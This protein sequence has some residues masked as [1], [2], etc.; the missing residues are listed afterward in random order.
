MRPYNGAVRIITTHLTADFDAFAAAVVARRL[1]PEHEVLFPGSLE[2]A[3]RRFLEESGFTFEELR[4]R[5]AR[6]AMVGHAVVVDTRNPSRLG[7]V[8]GLIEAANAPVTLIDHHP[9][10]EGGIESEEDLSRSA[11]ATSTII[12]SLLDER[13]IEPSPEEASLLLMGIH[14]DT[15]SLAYAETTPEDHRAAAWLLERGASLEWVRRW[16]A[17]GLEPSQLELLGRLAEATEERVVNGVRVAI[18]A[19][20]VDRYHEEAAYVVHRWVET[21]DHPV[22][23]ALIQNPPQTNV[24]I[25]S[26]VPG[27]DAGKLAARFGGGGHPAAASARV[28]G[29]VTV[30]LRERLLEAL[31]E[32][33]PRLA[34]ARDVAGRRLFTVP[35]SETVAA[36]KE[37]MNEL[38]VNALP[39]RETGSGALAGVVTRQ[40]LDRALAHGLADRPVAAVMQPGVPTVDAETL[41]EELRDLFLERSYR[42]VV[43]EEEGRPI[44]VVTRMQLFRHLFD[45][46]RRAG[47]SLDNRM[48]GARLVSQGVTRLL[49]EVPPEW[50]REVLPVVR[51]VAERLDSPVYLVGGMVRDLLLGRPSEDVDLV[52]E[53][54]GIVFAEALA[55]ETGG[56]A[57]PHP[58]FLTSIVTLPDGNHLDV[59]TARTEFYRTPAAL[60]EV[61]TS[62][63]RQDLYRRDFTINALAVVLSGDR[64]GQ[65]LD[66]FGGRRDLERGEIRVL[67]SLSFI[68]D[69]TRA[70]RAVR[71]ARRLGFEIAPDTRQ[72]IGTAIEEDVFTRLSGQR[73]RRELELLLAE[74]HPAESLAML[75]EL[76]LLGAL[77]AAL[78]WNRTAHSYLLDL[79]GLVEWYTLGGLGAAPEPLPLFLGGLA[80]RSGEDAAGRLAARLA[81]A[82]RVARSFA[83]LPADTELFLELSREGAPVSRIAETVERTGPVPALL[84]MAQLEETARRRMAEAMERV[85]RLELPV[86]GRDLVEAGLPPGPH[87]G[88]GLREARRAVLD[89]RVSPEDAAAVALE[90]ARAA[91]EAE[92]PAGG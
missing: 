29:A 17:K 51:R 69:P 20:D 48:A 8:W 37:R 32:E 50:V 77:D 74:P 53:G 71:Y 59:A 63:I 10:S 92:A 43:V 57:H 23:I 31:S 89:G 42:F 86:R 27:F 68:D 49:R 72:L 39:V 64:Y 55:G 18:A 2:L 61:E 33:L 54:D 67:H 12:V 41:L 85:A 26:R 58:P 60:P 75:A 4:L 82:G 25:R 22:G 28:T 36:V 56:R 24:I 34:V 65:L 90:A 38:K 1:F 79:E 40:I 11:G 91:M 46:Q 3:V 9:P 45:H 14:E 7:E 73:L 15:G 87:I 19:V 76:G 62:L 83:A 47:L 81:M 13:G 21:F 44:G 66:F 78:E 70:I 52:V 5:E 80:V 84:A 30:E 6:K 88:A 16:V 35:A